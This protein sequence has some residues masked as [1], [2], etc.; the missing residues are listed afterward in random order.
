MS[1]N[2]LK[3]KIHKKENESSKKDFTKTQKQHSAALR[4]DLETVKCLIENNK[5]DQKTGKFCSFT[6]RFNKEASYIL[7]SE[8]I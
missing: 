8:N 3:K 2:E 1:G 4:G 7:I 5:F 6:F